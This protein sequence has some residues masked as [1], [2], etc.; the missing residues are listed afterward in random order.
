MTHSPAGEARGGT[1]RARRGTGLPRRTI[2]LVGRRPMAPAWLRSLTRADVAFGALL[3]AYG[4]YAAVYIYRTSFV[5]DGERYFALFDDAMISMTYARTLARGYGLVWYPGAPR[6]EG[7]TNPLWTLVMALLHLLP[8]PASKMSLLVQLLA[9]LLLVA[10]LFLVRRV[11]GLIVPGS[12]FAGL[13]AVVLTAFYLPLNTWALQGMEVSLLTPLITAAAYLA[14][15]VLGD[16][17]SPGWLCLLLGA[18]T[19]VRPDMAV[20]C[21]AF[22]SY[23]ALADRKRWRTHL[24]MG[25][26]VPALFLAA[27]TLLRLWY[28]G[29]PLP[30][31][32]YLKMTGFPVLLRVA[33]GL[34]VAMDFAWPIGWLIAI[35]GLGAL[36]LRREGQLPLLMWIFLGQVAYSIYVGGDAWEWWGGANRYI[37]VAIPLLFLALTSVLARIG[38][39]LAARLGAGGIPYAQWGLIVM[40]FLSMSSFAASPEGRQTPADWL[41]LEP[42]FHVQGNRDTAMIARLVTDVTATQAR[43]AVVWA[44][45]IPYF[46]ERPCVDLLGKSDARIAHLPMR[47]SQNPSRTSEFYPGH[48][49]FDYGYSIGELHPD[50]VAQLWQ[51]PWEA[52]PYLDAHY[53][54]VNIRGFDLYLL[55]GSPNILW[56]KTGVAAAS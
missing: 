1:G 31:T 54:K 24:L 49:K 7:F 55:K 5:I 17:A 13:G 15:R 33:R 18:G 35:A 32:Y 6:V 16:R 22:A 40:A 10:N 47:L 26:G 8:L 29:S 25:L 37:V 12:S 52:Q 3:L 11:A 53:V 56:E 23:L 48:L 38:A 42:P 36:A 19:L 21:L 44:G 20:P 50:I 41:L 34:R 4:L 45:A 51:A 2:G 46:S 30:N 39:A 28:Y 14:L 27:Q 43:V 9:A